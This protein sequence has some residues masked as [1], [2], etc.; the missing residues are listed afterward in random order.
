MPFEV[1]LKLARRVAWPIREDLVPLFGSVIISVVALPVADFQKPPDQPSHRRVCHQTNRVTVRLSLPRA[2]AR[3][4][5][6]CNRL[7]CLSTTHQTLLVRWQYHPEP[8]VYAQPQVPRRI[9]G[10][11]SDVGYGYPS[12]G[13]Y[14]PASSPSCPPSTYDRYHQEAPHYPHVYSERPKS[15]YKEG[16]GSPIR[17]RH[18]QHSRYSP[19][20]LRLIHLLG[21]IMPDLARHMDPGHKQLNMNIYP[22]APNLPSP[23]GAFT[24]PPLVAP[25][26]STT[27]ASGSSDIPVLG[28]MRM[29]STDDSDDAP[30]PPP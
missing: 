29:S 10:E 7:H 23:R 1:A 16:G 17:D 9:S 18:A 14:R 8:P 13:N 21:V 3:A 20:L 11:I 2:S 15:S 25:S 12:H 30:R 5:G 19:Y 26:V 27:R 4:G 28:R 6:L 22:L 24:L